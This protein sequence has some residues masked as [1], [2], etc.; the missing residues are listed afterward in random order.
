MI[1]RILTGE[2]DIAMLFNAQHREKLRTVRNAT[3]TPG[4]AMAPHHPLAGSRTLRLADC[5][6]YP[7]V[8]PDR[9]LGLRTVIDASF[10]RL[11]LDPMSVV[12]TNS[13]VLMKAM[14]GDGQHLALLNGLDLRA[15]VAAGRFVFA[16]V[17][18]RLVA[19]NLSL[20]VPRD[21]RLSPIA[22]VMLAIL[23][24]VFEALPMLAEGGGPQ[25]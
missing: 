15:D 22:E 13:I 1:A 17:E 18:D 24:E 8:L 10:A 12:A 6:P 11:R 20:V 2:I 3:I 9:S 16:R 23:T 5:V 14:I 7:F 25:D 4:L 21:R 19:E